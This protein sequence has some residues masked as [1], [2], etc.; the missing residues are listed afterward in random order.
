M[1]DIDFP[2]KRPV[3]PKTKMPPCSGPTVH[4]TVC[5]GPDVS[6]QLLMIGLSVGLMSNLIQVIMEAKRQDRLKYPI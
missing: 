6:K 1:K 5:E 3:P 4:G 2:I